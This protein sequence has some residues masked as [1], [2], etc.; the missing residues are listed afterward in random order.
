MHLE[1][2]GT[3]GPLLPNDILNL[4][5]KERLTLNLFYSKTPINLLFNFH[6][7]SRV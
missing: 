5:A 3:K 2:S 6:L 1:K 4:R 7:I